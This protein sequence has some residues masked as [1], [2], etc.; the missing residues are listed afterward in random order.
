MKSTTVP[1]NKQEETKPQV[2]KKITDR[3]KTFED[4]CK[5]LGYS[6]DG[7]VTL[8]ME[9]AAIDRHQAGIIAFTKLSIIAQA[10]NEGWLPNWSDTDEY[11]WYPWFKHDDESGFGFSVSTYDGWHPGT[12]VGSRLCFRTEALSD[13]AGKQ[14]IEIY[15]QLLTIK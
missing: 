5:E 12:G 8:N 4:A 7:T 10:L 6:P 3:I 14:F 2:K 1:L 15:R 11:K 9:Q 13:Y